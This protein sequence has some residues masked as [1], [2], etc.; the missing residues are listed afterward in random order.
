MNYIIS[1]FGSMLNV[2]L[3]MSYGSKFTVHNMI[4]VAWN[5]CDVLGMISFVF[6]VVFIY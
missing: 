6:S 4:C 3:I 1:L 5:Q 2:C